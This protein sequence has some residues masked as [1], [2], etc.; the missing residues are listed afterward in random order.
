MSARCWWCRCAARQRQHGVLTA[1]RVRGRAAS[2][3]T[4]WTWPPGS[5]TRPRSRSNWPRPAPS[6]SARR[7]SRI[8]SGSPPTCTTTSSNGCSPPGCPCRPWPP[9]VGPGQATDR[10]LATVADLDRTIAQ[11]RTS[12]FALQ[13]TPQATRRGLRARL[14]DVAAEQAD[15][16]G[17]DP[18]LRF[19]GVLDC[20]A[21]RL[22]EDLEAVLREALSNI[23][24]HAHA[25]TVEV[26]LT[27]HP[28]QVSLAGQRRRHRARPHHPTQRPGQPA[29]PRRTP[30][31]HPHPHPAA[32]HRN[33]AVLVDPPQLTTTPSRGVVADS[34]GRVT[35]A[36][37]E[38]GG[39]A[40][41]RRPP[42]F[43]QATAPG[44]G[45]DSSVDTGGWRALARGQRAERARALARQDHGRRI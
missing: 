11:I 2:P 43:G 37:R 33:P 44:K 4:T 1:A 12:I 26:D 6:S 21:R 10:V 25:H 3:P 29:P 23:A 8:A 7:C 41:L 13:Q 31:R 36:L 5:P 45:E 16:L 35:S 38:T 28:D 42:S 32:T 19:S 14:L 24:R 9:F 39:A 27:G 22:A 18:A 17:F 15:A 20:P 40:P 34:P 30:R